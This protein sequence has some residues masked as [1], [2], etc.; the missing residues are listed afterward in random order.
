MLISPEYVNL[1]KQLH[2][3]N[4]AF[5]CSGY[6]YAE[7]VCVEGKGASSILDYGCGK[8][9]L[10]QT[11]PGFPIVGYDPA[12]KDEDVEHDPRKLEPHDVVVCTDALEH[13]EPNS[14]AD[15][16]I[17]LSYLTKKK[18]IVAINTGPAKKFLSDG[19]NAHLCQYPA[20]VWINILSGLF[21]LV[22]FMK[23]GER[24]FTAVLTPKPDV[25][26][27]REEIEPIF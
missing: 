3:T 9:T 26:W 25:S 6:R 5:G 8:R 23:D 14:L 17:H 19:R 12:T 10:E 2:E 21:D 22:W 15:V 11:L 24:G 1:N 27:T 20:N 4:P 13:I 7:I 18:L 16:V